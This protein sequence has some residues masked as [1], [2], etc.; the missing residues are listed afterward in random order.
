MASLAVLD[1]DRSY[2]DFHDDPQFC[3]VSGSLPLSERND[4]IVFLRQAGDRFP[5]ESAPYVRLMRAVL[6]AENME[7][8]DLDSFL[9]R[10]LFS[11]AFTERLNPE[12]SSYEQDEVDIMNI[13]GFYVRLLGDLPLFL[14]DSRSM[15]TEIDDRDSQ[16]L[17]Q[18]STSPWIPTQIIS[19]GTRGEVRDDSQ[20]PLIITWEHE[21]SQL[22]Y[23][24]D[25]L[26]TATPGSNH[27]H[28]ADMTGLTL[29]DIIDTIAFLNAL[30]TALS[31]SRNSSGEAE[32]MANT[33][34]SKRFNDQN[35]E[36]DLIAAIYDIFEYQLQQQREPTDGASSAEL[37]AHCIQFFHAASIYQP[38][39]IWPLFARSG[40]LGFDGG[41]CGL[42]TIVTAV[43]MVDGQYGFLISCLRLFDALIDLS[44][45][46]K[47]TN[48]AN[49]SKTLTRFA[50]ESN[51]SSFHVPAKTIQAV[52][53]G[54]LRALLPMF[55]SCR[56]WR[57][58][59]STE[60]FEVN[61]WL[62]IAFEKILK[63]TYGYD[64]NPDLHKKFT[65]VLA[66]PA[67]VLT[68]LFR[69]RSHLNA[70]SHH[71]S[72]TSSL[73]LS[74]RQ[75]WVWK[76]STKPRLQ[77][78]KQLSDYARLCFALASSVAVLLRP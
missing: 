33:I 24:I 43:E 26:A 73:G 69:S 7:Y 61:T 77:K 13:D 71:S 17:V 11:S 53:T 1:A 36:K 6:L 44:F 14:S 39:R 5:L 19:A 66:E 70:N 30:L 16:A 59:S 63:V 67:T 49:G 34:L 56:H 32:Q 48:V 60:Q 55:E 21:Y 38:G 22:H 18:T 37:L 58:V 51:N 4:L 68:E 47:P 3:T 8:D 74:N 28:Y 42:A 31:H 35:G 50:A 54:F 72:L 75:P 2:W 23:L 52:I 20:R 10:E 45:K 65:A 27:I 57:Y 46:H 41:D 78:Q 40:L 76:R 62:L 15:S 9:S 64:D 12:F 29:D 25:G